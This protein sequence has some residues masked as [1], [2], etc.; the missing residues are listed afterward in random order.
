MHNVVTEQKKKKKKKK[1]N[2][3][4]LIYGK[5]CFKHDNKVYTLCMFETDFLDC[6]SILEIDFFPYISRS[7]F[8]F[9]RL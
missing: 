8:R 4:I 2:T 6:I 1:K 9:L 3:K 5:I 7:Y